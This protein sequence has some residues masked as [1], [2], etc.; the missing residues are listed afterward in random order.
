MSTNFFGIVQEAVKIRREIHSYPEPGFE[1]TETVKRIRAFLEAHAS[2]N[3]F[4][5]CAENGLVVDLIGRCSHQLHQE[6]TPLQ[7]VKLVALRADTDALPMT[8]GNHGLPYRSKNEGGAE[9][10]K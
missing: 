10:A 2:V 8:E 5:P 3:E 7:T 6:E 4:K 1:V 9:N